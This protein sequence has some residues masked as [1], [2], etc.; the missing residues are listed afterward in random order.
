MEEIEAVFSTDR[1]GELGKSLDTEILDVSPLSDEQYDELDYDPEEYPNLAWVTYTCERF[2]HDPLLI[3]PD[4]PR[5]FHT[6]RRV[7]VYA[8][9][10]PAEVMDRALEHQHSNEFTRGSVKVFETEEH[11]WVIEVEGESIV[12]GKVE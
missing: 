3:Q 2:D 6:S 1:L 10:V 4:W 11:G 5:Y 8:E 9:T 7:F 12:H